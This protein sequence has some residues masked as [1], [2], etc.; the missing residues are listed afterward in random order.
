MPIIF[1][2]IMPTYNSENTI[3]YSL[4]SIK[5]QNY[6]KDKIECLIIDGGSTDNTLKIA[7]EYAFVKILSNPQKLPE[8]AKKIGAEN[9][10]GKYIIKMDSDEELSDVNSLKKR[11]DCFNKYKETHV[12]M[13]DE[14][15]TDKD[16]RKKYGIV[17]KYINICGDPF[18]FFMYRFKAKRT[19]KFKKRKID[20]SLYLF[21]DFK[22]PVIDGGTSTFDRDFCNKN[23][24]DIADNISH[25]SEVIL[26]KKPT[27]I[28]IEGDDAVHRS[29]AHFMEYCSKLKYRVTNN[30][31][32][33]SEAGF[34]SRHNSTNFKKY[35]FPFYVLCILP[36]CVDS[37]YLSVKYKDITMMLHTPFSFI[38]LFYIVWFSF[39]KIFNKQPKTISY[40]GK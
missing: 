36:V 18:S 10:K 21:D 29:K 2:F 11:E 19:E 26:E 8:C 32:K 16:Y 22:F 35:L 23:N 7:Q 9:A 33:K 12:L 20:E 40:G 5:N 14:L 30:I 38:T 31:F 17:A 25:I 15:K 4:D 28:C 37:V 6:D 24:I 27:V 39:F 3:R 34:S 13:L 1:S